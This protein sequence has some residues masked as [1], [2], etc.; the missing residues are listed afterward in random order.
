M[1]VS[2]TKLKPNQLYRKCLPEE[3][4][5]KTTDDL[6][7]IGD[8]D[9]FVG[10]PRAEQ[11]LDF[12]VGIKRDGYNIFALGAPGAG[13]HTFITNLLECRAKKEKPPQDI[14][15]VNNFEK[16]HAPKLLALKAG[17]AKV[18]AEDMTRLVEDVRN[19]MR[20][21]LENEE[22][23]NRAQS[24]AQELMEK[25]QSSYEEIREKARE[26]GLQ[27][28]PTPS[29]L[30]FAPLKENGGETFSPDEFEKLSDEEKKAHRRENP[31]DAEGSPA[32]RTEHSPVAAGGPRK[33]KGLQPGSDRIRDLPSDRRAEGQVRRS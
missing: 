30:A 3:L 6:A 14:C 4:G 22:Y 28:V 8:S 20:A 12:G 33:A 1:P 19:A 17:K 32:H 9:G 18:L 10:Q 21:A 2:D 15:Y 31:G 5:F 23:Q 24:I 26:K 13:R 11:A 29:G 7:D 27:I 25:Q 16:Q